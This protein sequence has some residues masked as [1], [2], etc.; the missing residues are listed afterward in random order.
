M[1]LTQDAVYFLAEKD[2]VLRKSPHSKTRGNA[3]NHLILGDAL[4]YLNETV[5]EWAKFYC[6]RKEGWLKI[7][8][9][10]EN[11][12]LEVNFVDI[13]QGDGCHIVTPADE[14][15]LIDAGEGIGFDRKGGDNMYRFLNWRYNL[16]HRKV[17]GIDGIPEDAPDANDKLAVAYAIM[18]HP[19]LDHYYGFYNL[20]KDPKIAFKK[21]GH[22]GIVE[23]SIK[24]GSSS[25]WLYDFGRKVPPVPYKRKYHLWDT[26]L[27]HTEMVNLL[28]QQIDSSKYYLKTLVAA[29]QNN[30]GITFDFLDQSKGFLD[31]FKAPNPLS[32]EILAPITETINHNGET[33]E[34]LIK[35]GDE[36][37][38]KNGHSV[39]FQLRYGKV[40]MILG[41]DLNSLSQD[42]LAQFYAGT[43]TKLSDLEKTI[44]ELN[45]AL[46]STE[47]TAA[48]QDEINAQL[49]IAIEE[50]TTIIN[51]VKA[52][53]G[54]DIAKACHH[55]SSDVLNS[56]LRAINP[57]ATVIS[58]GDGES[59]SHPRPD[60]LGA[61]GKS[62]RGERPLIFS[63]EL[64]RSTNEFSYPF[65]FY[66]VL[67]KL[68]ERMHTMTNEADK[69]IYRL[70]ME[71]LRDSNVARYGMITVR[72][73]G[74]KVIIA[75]KLEQS[76]GPDK[77]WDIYSLHWNE[78]LG[79]YE[80]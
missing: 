51:K 17:K 68:E 61:Y 73:D 16:R 24:D 34:C 11:R 75:Q 45:Q 38:T 13:G 31:H 22:N 76:K 67:K 26:V 36:S 60:A 6:R 49:S 65:K 78:V 15:I 9:V 50:Q 63:T 54:T 28:E 18:T 7:D 32:I 64:A 41:G 55:G 52:K 21:I 58:S 37:R 80:T 33:R 43:K 39:V 10:T 5:G 70:R 23:R 59:H 3:L 8:W 40:K 2:A 29:Y 44:E 27:N 72:T 66:G 35:L 46:S 62:S 77:K 71:N 79:A 48:E 57:L 53:F 69:E 12:L 20:F 42:Y 25:T 30:P 19:D 74:E 47:T 14:I 56:F 4:K 1:S